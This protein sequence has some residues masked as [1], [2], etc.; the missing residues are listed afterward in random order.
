[1]TSLRYALGIDLGTSGTRA[2]VIDTSGRLIAES[3]VAGCPVSE[4]C[5]R[6]V[7]QSPDC[8]WRSVE[9]VI[10]A[11]PDLV[12]P[13]IQSVA[14]NGTSGT[15]LLCDAQGKPLTAGLMYNDAR[16]MIQAEQIAKVAAADSAAHGASAS[17]AKL[18]WLVDKNPGLPAHYALHQADWIAGCLLQSWGV[19]DHNNALKLG[20][21]PVN[22]CWPSWLTQLPVD[23]SLLP[24]VFPPGSPIGTID[25]DIANRLKLSRSCQIMAGTTDSIAAFIATGA[26]QTGEAVTALGSTLV[27]KTLSPQ[28]V[29][30]AKFGIYSHKLG[31]H[32]LVG[33][34]SNSGGA[35]LAQYF[36]PDEIRQYSS[37]IHPEHDSGL[38][39]YP[40]P[41]PGER[42]P[43]ADPTLPPRIQPVPD[44][45]SP[46]F[47]QGLLEGIARI[48]QQGYQQL[49]ALGAP[50]PRSI[51]TTG[52]GA[53]NR[54]WQKIRQRLLGCPINTPK[55]S[56]AS[57]GSA[58]LATWNFS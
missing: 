39:Y 47:L 19:S 5:H 30:S 55:H 29:F 52:G 13:K 10:H 1:M 4:P 53:A 24:Q 11:L 16:A 40:L 17:L 50:Y 33:G 32:W 38:D 15:L 8:W 31:D 37:L 41:R 25:P 12:K 48:E 28:P 20:Y 27:L 23:H 54:N 9:S 6:G 34:A 44:N 26:H 14:V 3:Q 7:E 49:A 35:V 46:R 22:A 43:I 58:L 51:F 36:S 57:Y 2:T 21:D 56:E 42:F 18:L 45:D